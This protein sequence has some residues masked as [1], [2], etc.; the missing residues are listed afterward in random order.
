MPRLELLPGLAE[1]LLEFRVEGT[2][3]PALREVATVYLDIAKAAKERGEDKSPLSYV[4]RRLFRDLPQAALEQVLSSSM[5]FKA[6]RWLSPGYVHA[7]SH[8]TL[9]EAGSG[10]MAVCC[11]HPHSRRETTRR[12]WDAALEGLY[13]HEP[14]SMLLQR[15]AVILD[16]RIDTVLVLNGEQYGLEKWIKSDRVTDGWKR[17]QDCPPPGLWDRQLSKWIN[18]IELA[19][20]HE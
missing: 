1:S 20:E 5:R 9:S 2:Y 12:C 10:P 19:V 18:P 15:I 11:E 6:A 3:D 8:G 16:S 14:E 13:D 17:Y 7:Y 4:R